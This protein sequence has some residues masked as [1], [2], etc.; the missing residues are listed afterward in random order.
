MTKMSKAGD[1]LNEA[2][3]DADDMDSLYKK[4][5]KSK[6]FQIGDIVVVEPNPG[7]FWIGE[8]WTDSIDPG[9]I[10]V[11][12]GI[13]GSGKARNII[14]AGYARHATDVEA[15]NYREIKSDKQGH[16]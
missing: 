7:D 5:G 6:D 11:L 15:A 1:F 3:F 12:Y 4:V 2:D 10:K 8:V 14:S 13:Y 16:D 9:Y